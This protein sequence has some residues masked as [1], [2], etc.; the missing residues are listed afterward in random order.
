MVM[1]THD[2]NG[3]PEFAIVRSFLLQFRPSSVA[4]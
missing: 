4:N 2:L 3:S 1:A